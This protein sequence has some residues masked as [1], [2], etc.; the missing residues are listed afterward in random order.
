MERN[1]IFTPDAPWSPGGSSQAITYNGL[2]YVSDQL[3]IDPA[4]GQMLP[5]P[6]N[7]SF[8]GGDQAVDAQMRQC[9]K[10]L[11][12]ICQAAGT[13]L[14]NAIK[15][16]IYTPM[17]IQFAPVIDRVFREFF[18]EFPPARSMIGVNVLQGNALVQ[19]DAIVP[20]I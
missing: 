15:L 20:L 3:P 1:V 2:L 4:T 18:T 14:S 12:A 13:D 8:G 11:N 17:L 19:I 7:P 6:L 9:L 5:R 10:N 16:T